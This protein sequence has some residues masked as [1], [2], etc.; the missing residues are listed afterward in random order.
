MPVLNGMPVRGGVSIMASSREPGI[1]G[2]VI[3]TAS[4]R[5]AIA[6]LPPMRSAVVCSA[7]SPHRDE[8]GAPLVAGTSA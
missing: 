1:G 3:G 4:A 6:A 2:T 8:V 7:V 5:R